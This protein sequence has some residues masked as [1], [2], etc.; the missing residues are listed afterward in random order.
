MTQENLNK[1]ESELNDIIKNHDNVIDK[2]SELNQ[3]IRELND[4]IKNH[5]NVIDKISKLNQQIRELED[6]RVEATNDIYNKKQEIGWVKKQQEIS[7]KKTK[8]DA[9]K[10]LN[11]LIP[12]IKAKIVKNTDEEDEDEEDE[13][14]DTESDFFKITKLIKRAEALNDSKKKNILLF[15]LIFWLQ[16]PKWRIAGRLAADVRGSW[17]DA[18][19]RIRIMEELLGTEIYNDFADY[20]YD[21]RYFRDCFEPYYEFGP[22]IK[23]ELHDLDMDL[24]DFHC[25]DYFDKDIYDDMESFIEHMEYKIEKLEK[26]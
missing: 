4:I 24:N 19:G 16:D 25:I 1:L 21:G 15:N 3:Q 11:N 23:S 5:D 9:M 14:E 26:H 2:I 6:A 18:G 20:D 13:E 12:G 17:R 10:L 8:Q 7:F 22:L